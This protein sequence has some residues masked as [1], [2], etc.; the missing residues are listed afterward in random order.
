MSD[1]ELRMAM[2][3]YHASVSYG[4]DRQM[5]RLLAALRRLKLE[6]DTVVVF[7]S[8]H[9]DFMGHHHM[10]RKSMFLY[11]SLLHVPMIWY[12]P[13]RIPAGQRMTELVQLVDLFPTFAEWCSEAAPDYC[14]GT[15]IKTALQGDESSLR[16]RTIFASAGYA[17]LPED[18]FDNPEPFR[19]EEPKVRLHKRVKN[20]MGEDKYRSVMART[21]DWKYI[22]S[23]T[24]PPE[25]YKLDGGT[26]EREN[27]AEVAEYADVRKRMESI[28]QEQIGT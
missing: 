7:T 10:V 24:R 12:A 6:E 26:V 9:G 15:S 21:K 8:D 20:V 2:R 18:Y 14:S 3:Y 5:G 17:E 23:E 13:G 11:D 27:V 25:L 22:H 28:L 16:D 19:E 4:V 1:A